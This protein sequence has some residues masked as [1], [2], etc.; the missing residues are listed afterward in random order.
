MK[1]LCQSKGLGGFRGFAYV[2]VWQWEGIPVIGH[3]ASGL[4]S[5]GLY[6]LGTGVVRCQTGM[7]VEWGRIALSAASALW[8]TIPRRHNDNVEPS[9][10]K[11]KRRAQESIPMSIR[12]PPSC[13]ALCSRAVSGYR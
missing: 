4:P 7:G 11:Q 12:K 10:G 1:A 8:T 2:L 5:K 13:T 9:S 3:W 6:L